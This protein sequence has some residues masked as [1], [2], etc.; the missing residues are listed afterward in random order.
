M[1][2]AGAAQ[3][4]IRTDITTTDDDPVNLRDIDAPRVFSIAR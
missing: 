1:F 2:W 4:A 3:G